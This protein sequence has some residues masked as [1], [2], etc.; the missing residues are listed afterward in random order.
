M[1]CHVRKKYQGLISPFHVLKQPQQLCPPTNPL[2]FPLTCFWPVWIDNLSDFI[3]CPQ[4]FD[5]LVIKSSNH[6]TVCTLYPS[7]GNEANT[8]MVFY[9]KSTCSR[10]NKVYVRV[11][12]NVNLISKY[13]AIQAKLLLNRGFMS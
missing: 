6:V 1:L 5:S 8:E 7:N 10:H 2:P 13:L 9:R 12:L 11:A 4:K 3:S